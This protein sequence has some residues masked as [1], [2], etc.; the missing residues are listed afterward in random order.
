MRRL[1]SPL[2]S[3]ALALSLSLSMIAGVAASEPEPLIGKWL[4]ADDDAPQ[5]G[6]S[7]VE[8]YLQGDRLFARILKTMDAHGNE[9]DP[10]C[11]NCPGELK[12]KPTKGVVFVSDLR[13]QGDR[14]VDGRVIDLR[15]GAT[16]GWIATCD[17][18]LIDSKAVLHGYLGIRA[19][20]KSSYWVRLPE[21]R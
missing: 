18:T 15:A 19:L 16:Q 6:S 17:L 5:K 3:T 2:R 8:T 4:A 14:W 9:I 7:I 1:G 12:G 21:T 10:V 20:G 11:E 13:K